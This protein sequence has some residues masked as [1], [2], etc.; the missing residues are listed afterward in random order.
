MGDK[1]KQSCVVNS[2]FEIES[3]ALFDTLQKRN[4]LSSDNVF[5]WRTCFNV[6]LWIK[7]VGPLVGFILLYIVLG[8]IFG[9]AYG[10]ALPFIAPLF[11][12]MTS[13]IVFICL[14]GGVFLLF[15][16]LGIYRKWEKSKNEYFKRYQTN[17]HAKYQSHTVVKGP[18]K[19]GSRNA[20]GRNTPW[21]LQVKYLDEHGK[22]Q[23]AQSYLDNTIVLNQMSPGDDI[24]ICRVKGHFGKK[25]DIALICN[26]YRNK[27]MEKE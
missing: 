2:S 15:G 21:V 4:R 1:T 25:I 27:R 11:G 6:Y 12:L 9:K 17:F 22:T 24:V 8:Y 7:Y 16:L 10:M 20:T 18:M 26:F 23:V 3:K 5:V 19:M 13:I 14:G